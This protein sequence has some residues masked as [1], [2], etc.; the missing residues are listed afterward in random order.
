[1]YAQTQTVR[2]AV[3]TRIAAAKAAAQASCCFVGLPIPGFNVDL[4]I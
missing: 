1:M 3:P 4:K 2:A